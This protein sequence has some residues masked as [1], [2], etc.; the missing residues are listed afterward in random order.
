MTTCWVQA[1]LSALH[2]IDPREIID[3]TVIPVERKPLIVISAP[4]DYSAPDV[5]CTGFS[6]GS[7]SAGWTIYYP[8]EPCWKRTIITL[9]GAASFVPIDTV[10]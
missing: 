6:S 8:I 5:F 3:D 1:E 10:T 9:R 7:E 2:A 4:A